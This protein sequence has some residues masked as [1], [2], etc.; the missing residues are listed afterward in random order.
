MRYHVRG[1]ALGAYRRWIDPS[2]ESDEEAE[3]AILEAAQY[4]R[5]VRGPDAQG[6]RRLRAPRR[7]E[8]PWSQC[9]LAVGPTGDIIDV[10]PAS[11]AA[12][13]AREQDHP[14]RR[15]RPPL[16]DDERR[17]M[18]ALRVPPETASGLAELA[19]R[20]NVSQSDAVA[21]LVRDRRE[22]RRAR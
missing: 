3:Q 4:S 9:Y 19:E 16:P 2:C 7:T 22:R 5:E 15:G 18:V 17:V 21:R 6:V 12:R 13:R 20:W 14:P 10:Q 11:G 1:I 8:V